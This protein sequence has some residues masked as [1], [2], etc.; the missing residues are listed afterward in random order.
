VGPA[1][2]EASRIETLCKSLGRPMLLSESFATT[3][4]PHPRLR[5]LGS[6]SLAGIAT[7]RKIFGIE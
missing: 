1:V 3:L 2:N 5:E 7:P 4:G 6:H